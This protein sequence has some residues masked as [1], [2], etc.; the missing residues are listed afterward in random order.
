MDF[1]FLRVSFMSHFCMNIHLGCLGVS[2]AG[3]DES[4]R[5]NG[6]HRKDSPLSFI[7]IPNDLRKVFCIT[8]ITSERETDITYFFL[9][10]LSFAVIILNLS[11]SVH[12]LLVLVRKKK[13]NNNSLCV[14]TSE[15]KAFC[16]T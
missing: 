8:E 14:Y 6:L 7:L 16:M 5:M 12:S 3:L 9:S 11:Q 13:N 2:F 10:I 4:D 1:S 15:I